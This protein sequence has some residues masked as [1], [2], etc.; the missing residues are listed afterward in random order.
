MHR[1]RTVMLLV[2]FINPMQFAGSEQLAP[3]AVE[4]AAYTAAL[5][6]RVAR[7]GVQCIYANDNYGTWHSEFA[8][9]LRHCISLGGPARQI[10]ELLAPKP[11]DLTI[12]KPRHSGFFCTPL[13]LLLAQMRTRHLII[14]GLAAD[15]CVQFTAMD[16]HLR[17]YDLWVPEDC[18]ASETP[19][20]KQMALTYLQRVMNA[21]TRPAVPRLHGRL[22]LPPSTPHPGGEF[23]ERLIGDDGDDA[24]DELLRDTL[25]VVNR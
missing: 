23:D 22:R 15:I 14:V 3:H 17:G 25:K 10:A 6:A 16:A 4:A 7:R 12:I 24:A 21:D 1:S 19:E 18:T 13:E 8:D 5:K 11:Q 2:D 9:V 20:R